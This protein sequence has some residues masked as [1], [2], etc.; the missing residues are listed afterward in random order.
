VPGG[1][2][3]HDAML[4][5]LGA[6]DLFQLVRPNEE[7]VT[8]DSE[9]NAYALHW[10]GDDPPLRQRLDYL[11]VRQGTDYRIV[12]DGQHVHVQGDG[13][14]EQVVTRLCRNPDTFEGWTF[15]DSSLQC[16]LSDHYGL[17]GHLRLVRA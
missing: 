14:N 15:D 9:R 4:A 8:Y 10:N 13:V 1:T 17:V 6:K 16:Y 3:E 5:T 12:V 11:L 7:G 2:P